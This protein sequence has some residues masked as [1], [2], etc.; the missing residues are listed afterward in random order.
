[1]AVASWLAALGCSLLL[2]GAPACGG[3]DPGSD[4]VG[5]QWKWSGRLEGDTGG[6]ATGLQP[7]SDPES[8]LLTLQPGGSFTA[9]ADCTTVDGTYSLSGSDLTLEVEP[10]AKDACA[11]GSLAHQ[12]VDLLR[13]V[14]TYEAHAEN[15]LALGLE[16][17]SGFLYFY[18]SPA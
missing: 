8:Y 2:L 12:Y 14:R 6:M 7:V 3:D 16:D 5:V 11:E 13:R 18:S 10:L 17:D 9:K 1:V 15:A 4:L